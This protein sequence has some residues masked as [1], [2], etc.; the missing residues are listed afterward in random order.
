[1]GFIQILHSLSIELGP[2][3]DINQTIIIAIDVLRKCF[4]RLVMYI[5]VYVLIS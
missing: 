5:Y 1:M 2:D 4:I 3:P